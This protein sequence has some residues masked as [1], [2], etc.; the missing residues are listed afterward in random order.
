MDEVKKELDEVYRA[1]T[2]I[3]SQ[4]D[5]GAVIDIVAITRAKIRHVFDEIGKMESER[6]TG[7][8]EGKEDLV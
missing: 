7:Q 3:P 4:R 6:N 8:I 2:T 1:I 5:A